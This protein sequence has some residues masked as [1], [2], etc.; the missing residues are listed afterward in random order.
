MPTKTRSW[1]PVGYTEKA[2][3]TVMEVG[4]LVVLI[5]FVRVY[6]FTFWMVGIGNLGIEI[7]EIDLKVRSQK[8]NL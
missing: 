7:L 5:V 1:L 8:L 4:Y 6:R 3:F 2:G